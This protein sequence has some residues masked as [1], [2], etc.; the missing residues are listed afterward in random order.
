M[1]QQAAPLP[2]LNINPLQTVKAPDTDWPQGISLNFWK[3]TIAVRTLASTSVCPDS[4]WE[5]QYLLALQLHIKQAPSFLI[6]EHNPSSQLLQGAQSGRE[7]LA[8]RRWLNPVAVAAM[9]M[10][11]SAQLHA[12]RGLPLLTSSQSR[13]PGRGSIFTLPQPF[14][15][16]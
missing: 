15:K 16:P 2:L 6:S 12:I 7:N 11:D 3:A 5:W 4:S 10:P 13:Q 8:F 14:Y 9:K 1:E